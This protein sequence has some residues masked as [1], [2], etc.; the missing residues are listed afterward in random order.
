DPAFAGND[1]SVCLGSGALVLVGTPVGGTWSG[2]LVTPGGILNTNVAGS[3]TLTYS[4][5]SATCLLQDQVTVSVEALPVVD[6]G[7]DISVCEEGGIQ[8]LVATPV[9]GTWSGTGVDPATGEFDPLQALP[10]GNPVSYSYTDPTTGCS[11]SDNA[12]VTVNPMPVAGFTHAPV[13]CANV[14]FQFTNTSSGN[15]GSEWDFGDGGTSFASSP[16]HV[17]TSTGAFDVTLVVSTGANCTDTITSTV[18]VWDVPD[19]QPLLDATNGCGPFTVSFDNN[20]LG[21]GLSYWWDFGGLGTSALQWPDDFTFPMDPQD[22]IVYPVTLTASN[23]CG[24]DAQTVN[25]TVMPSP[26]AVF[27]PNVNEYCAFAPVPFANVSY[28]LPDSFQ[29]DFGD[30]ATSS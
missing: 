11:N 5:G 24:S 12:V 29:W 3:Y 13:A 19:A 1:T 2:P 15:S 14:P 23:T 28:G 30:G 6:A 26:T 18:V 16:F 17:F 25:V 10:G 20:S 22:A 7:D 9:G 8:V 21:D 27:G 4:V